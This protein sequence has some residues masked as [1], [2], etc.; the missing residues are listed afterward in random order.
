[1]DHLVGGVPRRSTYIKHDKPVL[2]VLTVCVFSNHRSFAL[3]VTL[4]GSC[5]PLSFDKGENGSQG[6]TV[7]GS[8]PSSVRIGKERTETSKATSSPHCRG[9]PPARMPLMRSD[10]QTGFWEAVVIVCHAEAEVQ[11]DHSVLSLVFFA[12]GLS[13]IQVFWSPLPLPFSQSQAN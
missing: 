10:M 3:E 6:D 13:G 12:H 2:S 11:N 1:M 9:F 8:R 5:W 7:T 4:E